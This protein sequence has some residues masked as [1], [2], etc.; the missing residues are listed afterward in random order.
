M[1]AA[2]QVSFEA[3]FATLALDVHGGDHGLQISL[4]AAAQALQTDP[5][6]HIILV[7]QQA[8][9]ESA[10]SAAGMSFGARLSLRHAPDILAMDAKPMAVLRR[11]HSSSMRLAW[12]AVAGLE[13]RGGQ[14]PWPRG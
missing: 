10:V 2:S 3:P 4:P 12:S 5:K 11:G 9:I 1:M 6:L 8:A 7:G 13:W 14:E